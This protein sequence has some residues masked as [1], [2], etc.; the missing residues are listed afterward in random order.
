LGAVTCRFTGNRSCAASSS[1]SP[2]IPSRWENLGMGEF[3]QAR[4]SFRAGPAYVSS[5]TAADP[6]PDD[7]RTT[8]QTIR[9]K[10][11]ALR[12]ESV[13]EHAARRILAIPAEK[14]RPFHVG[15][16]Q[17]AQQLVDGR[18]SLDGPPIAGRVQV[19]PAPLAVC[20]RPPAGLPFTSGGT[21]AHGC[22]SRGHDE[23]FTAHP[24][25][26]NPQDY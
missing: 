16:V 12:I 23:T 21:D 1:A 7:R 11:D 10:A 2:Q 24:L 8:G 14:D 4:K 17:R 22:R 20:L 15:A 9:V 18:K 6:A 5:R 19:R 26:C 13:L 25:P 3:A